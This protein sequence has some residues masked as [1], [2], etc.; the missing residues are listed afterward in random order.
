MAT[1]NVCTSDIRNAAV[2]RV[3]IRIPPFWPNDPEVWF[4]QIE[5]QFSIGGISS[6]ETKYNYVVGNLDSNYISEVRDIISR[7][8]STGKYEKIKTEIIRRLSTTQEEKTRR[9]LEHEEMGDRKPSQFLR[10]LQGLAGTA[11]PDKLVR[12]LWLG[13]LPASLQAILATQAKADNDTV[14]ELADAVFEALPKHSV[15]EVTPPQQPTNL[16]IAVEKLTESMAL[17]TS[18]VIQLQ[19]EIAETSSSR[20]TD[21]RNRSA[22]RGRSR[23]RSRSN[24]GGLCWYHFRFGNKA[25]K[26]TTPC[27]HSAGN[28]QGSH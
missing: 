15:L 23:S 16:E 7:P 12:S 27:S 4:L 6:D 26:C 9:L 18:K 25:K 3:S 24:N 13:R 2:E 1:E 20:R 10:R 19:G 14:A 8:P 17:L 22:S 21:Y 5:T 28:E 11:V